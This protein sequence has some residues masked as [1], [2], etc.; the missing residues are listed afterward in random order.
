MDLNI[1]LTV[2]PNLGQRVTGF[3]TASKKP[4]HNGLTGHA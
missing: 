2:E 1:I 3:F 4:K